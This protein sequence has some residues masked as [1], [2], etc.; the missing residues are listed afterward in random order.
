MPSPNTV[1]EAL[2]CGTP[3]V[4]MAVRGIPEREC[5]LLSDPKSPIRIPQSEV[6]PCAAQP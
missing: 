2:A 6:E 3:V 5:R 1:L 4:A